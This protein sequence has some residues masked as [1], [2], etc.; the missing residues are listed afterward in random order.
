ME[1]CTE[2][3]DYVDIYVNI[4]SMLSFAYTI[5][6]DMAN[7]CDTDTLEGST[8]IMN[9]ALLELKSDQ[10]FQ[11]SDFIQSWFT[12]WISAAWTEASETYKPISA[13]VSAILYQNDKYT[14]EY[15]E[16]FSGA[17]LTFNNWFLDEFV[18]YVTDKTFAIG[19]VYE[20]DDVAWVQDMLDLRNAS[21]YEFPIYINDPYSLLDISDYGDVPGL[22]ILGK[23]N[24]YLDAMVD[25]LN[26]EPLQKYDNTTGRCVVTYVPGNAGPGSNGFWQIPT[27]GDGDEDISCWNLF[28]TQEEENG[29]CRIEWQ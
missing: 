10:K 7:I 6:N 19:C 2:F 27:S 3:L 18:A 29:M 13:S 15:K 16:Y 14:N 26:N 12:P 21:P 20:Q 11:T 28:P 1:P 9:S 5:F 4:D 25:F 22:H 23:A 24:S 17:N 8:F